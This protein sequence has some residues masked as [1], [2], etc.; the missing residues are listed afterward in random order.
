MEV[1]EPGGEQH[2]GISE[3]A[4]I[5]GSSFRGLHQELMYR[6]LRPVRIRSH[7]STLKN[8]VRWK[9]RLPSTDSDTSPIYPLSTLDFILNILV[10]ET[11]IRLIMQDKGW[12]GEQP[13]H[14]PAWESACKDASQ[15]SLFRLPCSRFRLS[16]SHH[17]TTSAEKST[18]T[19]Y[20]SLYE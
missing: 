12:R 7:D 11:A 14:S 16:S 13:P 9:Y 17:S 18:G 19:Y 20:A 4:G 1:E 15:H 3:D 5:V 10:T 2:N 6:K 8:L